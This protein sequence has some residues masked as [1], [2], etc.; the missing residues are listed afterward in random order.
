MTKLMDGAGKPVGLAT[1]ERDITAH[2]RAEEN[3]RRM[4]TVVRD[5]NDAITIQDFEG[6]ITAWNRGAE[7]MYGYSE[8]EAFI[9]NIDLLTTPDKVEEQKD[10]IHCLIAGKAITSFETQR[11]TKDGR[12]LDIWMTVTKLMDDAGKPVGLAT[13][14]RDITEHKRVVEE[15]HKLNVE[16]E[17][18]VAERTDE[19][20]L[21]AQRLVRS[22]A[23]LKEFA[24]GVSHDLQEP[25]RMVTSYVQLLEKRY[26]GKLDPNADEFISYV[27]EGTIRMKQLLQ[28]LSDYSRVGTRSNPMQTVE[29]EKVLEA[30][31]KNL[32]IVLEETNGTITQGPLPIIIADEMQ[33]LQIFQNLIGNALKFH[34]PQPPL[35]HVSAKQEGKN[36][37]FS[38]Q[39]NGIGIDPL[40]FEKIFII[41][42]RLHRRDE[43]P[44]TGIGL[45]VV[46]KIVER[47]GGRIWVESELDK[48]TT[49]YFTIPLDHVKEGLDI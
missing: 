9:T 30:V 25:L 39:D 29:S 7:L 17:Q 21:Y 10:F 11:V 22:N 35:I 3:L 49:F 14:E 12:V 24:Y 37:I 42:Q 28:A 18:R 19:L 1:T 4:A 16:L 36:W 41:F 13:T 23:E 27:V 5:S 31:L 32:K 34:G 40:Y 48:G 2:K 26:K 46:R 15:V 45:A 43:Y 33:M 6:K 20:T 38:V 44:G 47:H 8:E